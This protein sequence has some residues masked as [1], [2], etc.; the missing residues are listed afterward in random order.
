M[1]NHQIKSSTLP[2]VRLRA[3]EPEDL[4]LLYHIENDYT[5]W[6]V[7]TTN[8]PYSRY[9]LHDYIAHSAGDIY[10]DKQV[11]LIIEREDGQ[12]IGIADIVNFDPKHRRA[13][14]GLVIE[15]PFRRQGYAMSAL[16]HLADYALHQIH[17]H[18]LYVCIAADNEASLGLFQKAGYHY[19]AVLHDWLYN[20]ERYVDAIL[21][22]CM[23]LNAD[24]TQNM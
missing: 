13:E 4:D 16:V 10:V 22:Q 2:Q 19:S 15:R 3:I 6:D 12:T 11:R 1:G 20:G 23:L 7:G 9:T 17:L 8:V 24:E 18:Q 21:L 5:L 14:L